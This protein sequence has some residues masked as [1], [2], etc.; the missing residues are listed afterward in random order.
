MSEALYGILGAVVVIGVIRPLFWWVA[1]SLSLW[2]GRKVCS[3]RVGRVVFGR[4][5]RSAR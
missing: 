5:W 4:Y 3:E 2:L 1:L